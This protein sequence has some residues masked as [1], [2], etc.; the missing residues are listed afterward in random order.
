M[1]DYHGRFTKGEIS[2]FKGK[3]HSFVSREKMSASRKGKVLTEQ[4]KARIRFGCIG[5][6]KGKVRSEETRKK[7][8]VTK[9]GIPSPKKGIRSGIV[10]RSDF[11]A[12]YTPWNKKNFIAKIIK[13]KRILKS[14]DELLAKKRFRNQ[15]YKASKIHAIGHHTFDEWLGLKLMY[16]N[17]CLCCKQQEPD[18]KLTEDHIVPLSM[19]GTDDIS[20]IQPLC[21]SC[22]TR[23]HA[24]IISYLPVG[25][26]SSIFALPN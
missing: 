24:R 22:N 10:P 23:K 9:K 8:S 16:K 15:R 1:R 5:I 17:M 2:L 7:I 21:V 13:H 3:T 25:N 19:G 20:N 12:G 26:N 14:K 11:K 4:H 6:N 18:I